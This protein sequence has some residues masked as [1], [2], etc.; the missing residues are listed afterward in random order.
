MT[1]GAARDDRPWELLARGTGVWEGDE[2]LAPAPWAP[3]GM[4]ARGRTE[5]RLILD[6]R[7][8]ASEYAQT[9]DGAVSLRSHTVLRWD[10]GQGDFVLH[11]FSEPG[12]GPMVLRG[13]RDGDRLVLEGDGP[14]GAMRQTMEYGEDM[15]RV[16]SESRGE[17]G[18]WATT[19]E[20]SYRK[21][22]EDAGPTPGSVAWRD[23][24]VDD[25][26]AV[27]D[28]YVA[29]VGWRP[30]G[31]SMGE[32]DDWNMVGP[33]GTPVAGVCHAR[34]SNAGLPPVWLLY[35]VVEDLD[36]SLEAVREGGGEV[37][38]PAR[39]MGDA[40][41]AV[42]RDPAGAAVALWEVG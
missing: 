9:V 10:E 39:A 3:D 34:G 13:R 7:G 15:L 36:A 40:R 5:A 8:L 30:E 31:V 27:R 18:A 20:G 41:W 24:T 32:Y 4:E 38:R 26:E 21:L 2:T 19:F 28:F 35:L 29:V 11:F 23:L 1:D 16:R 6:G 12:G 42:I 33:G 37:V 22:T 14:G 25:A 17:D